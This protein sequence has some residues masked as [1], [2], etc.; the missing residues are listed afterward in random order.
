MASVMNFV[1]SLLLDRFGRVRI[2]AI[3]LVSRPAI[4][5][6]W[7]VPRLFTI[8]TNQHVTDRVSLRLV[9]LH[10][11]CSILCWQHESSWEWLWNLLPL[12]FRRILRWLSRRIELRVRDRDISHR[13][14]HSWCWLFCQ[15]AF[16]L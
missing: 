14:P 2:M 9:L 16:P 5:Q 3:G 1:C 15:R 11:R 7:E 10:R 8:S 13:R 6:S 12:L 4:V